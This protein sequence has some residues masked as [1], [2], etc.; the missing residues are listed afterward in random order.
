MDTINVI[1]PK[2]GANFDLTEAVQDE[3]VRD[4]SDQA[5]EKAKDSLA[6]EMEDLRQQLV[7]KTKIAAD[8][9]KQELEIRK[10]QRELEEKNENLELEMERKLDQERKKIAREAKEK[11]EEEY[12]LKLVEK[13]TQ[14]ESVKAE[15]EAARRK[16]EQGSQQLQGEAAELSLED[17]LGQSFR[18]DRIDPVGK[19]VSGADVHQR[20]CTSDGQHCGTIIWE[21]KNTIHWND[22]W[23]SKLKEDQLAAK[24]ELAVIVSAT[25]PDDIPHFA[26]VDGVWV[27]GFPYALG[28]GTA[29]RESLMQA[30]HAR[31]SMEG[32]DEKIELLYRYLSGPE[33]RQ[34]VEMIVTTFVEMKNE[35]ES[36]KRSMTRIWGKREKSIEKVITNVAGMYGEMQGIVGAALPAIESLELPAL[37]ESLGG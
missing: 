32:K 8:A 24:A 18:Y 4:L 21:S 2:C 7:E 26:C 31:R 36:E 19:G 33:F 1:C 10:R 37:E 20:V 25:L 35:L 12:L 16:A 3:F 30:A 29:L 22:R 17:L 28:L 23:L 5:Q 27:T 34:R 9:R 13:D 11:T 15:L 14:L 6:L